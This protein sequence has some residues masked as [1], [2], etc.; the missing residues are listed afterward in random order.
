ME[1]LQR[2]TQQSARLHIRFSI[3]D[4][5]RL[6]AHGLELGLPLTATVRTLA[7][8]ALAGHRDQRL[9]ELEAVTVPVLVVQGERD[10]FGLPPAGP[11]REVVTIPGT[12]SLKSSGA[13]EAAVAAWL[14]KT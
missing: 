7:R 2:R 1:T 9:E 5:E 10:P 12:H 8:T 4:I 13:V 14:A 6:R 11:S 3:D